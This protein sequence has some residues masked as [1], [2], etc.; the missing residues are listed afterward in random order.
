MD[1]SSPE[2]L[3]GEIDSILAVPGCLDRNGLLTLL[4]GLEAEL[5]RRREGGSIII[6]V[7]I[8]FACHFFTSEFV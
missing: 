7:V 3:R 4:N 5:L 2:Q 6:D 1:V 8:M